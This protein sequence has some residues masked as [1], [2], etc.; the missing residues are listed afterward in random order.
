MVGKVSRDLIHK[1]ADPVVSEGG[2]HKLT[3]QEED[4]GDG[5]RN[6]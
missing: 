2:V 6:P 3:D 5:S 4:M 1:E